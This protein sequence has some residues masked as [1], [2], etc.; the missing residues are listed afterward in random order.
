ML[1]Q[2]SHGGVLAI[3][4]QSI[5]TGKARLIALSVSSSEY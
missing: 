3:T 4:P 5:N 1:A 2:A